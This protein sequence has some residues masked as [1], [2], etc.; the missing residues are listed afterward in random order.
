MEPSREKKKQKAIAKSVGF[1]GQ[2]IHKGPSD[3]GNRS[4][5]EDADL[6]AMASIKAENENESESESESKSGIIDFD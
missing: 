3:N 5:E 4:P 1:D 6:E 2:I